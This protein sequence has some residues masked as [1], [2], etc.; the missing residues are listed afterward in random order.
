MK[1]NCP[2]CQVDVNWEDKSEFRP[3]CSKRCQMID[4]GDWAS[5]S[6]AIA[7]KPQATSGAPTSIDIEE[8]EAALA[9]QSDSFFTH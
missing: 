8:I 1:V 5:E 2:T 3:F 7:G 9:K 4:L 6:N